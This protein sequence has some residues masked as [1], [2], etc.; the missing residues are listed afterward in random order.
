[1]NVQESFVTALDGSEIYLRKWLPEGDPRGIIQIAHGMTEHA[2]VYTE[3][4][5][6][7]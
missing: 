6:A 7:L 1:M 4:V 3:F 2:G 5:D